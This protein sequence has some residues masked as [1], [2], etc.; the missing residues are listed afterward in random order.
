MSEIILINKICK[1]CAENYLGKKWQNYCCIKCRTKYR[2]RRENNLSIDYISK[3][4]NAPGKGC[5]RKD[6]YVSKSIKGKRK[7]EHTLIMQDFL[8]RELI[9]GESVHHINGVKSDNRIENLELWSSSHPTGQRV[10]DKVKWAKEFLEFH[11]YFVV[12]K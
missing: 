11:G 7:L 9:K 5:L 12:L 2:Y 10:E 1:M 3:I 8:G 6:G 4:K